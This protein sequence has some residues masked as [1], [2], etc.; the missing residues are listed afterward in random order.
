VCANCHAMLHRAKPPLS[1]EALAQ[2]I[3]SLRNGDIEHR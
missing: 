3:N 1:V 2:I